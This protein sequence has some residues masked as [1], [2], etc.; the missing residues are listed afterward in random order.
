MLI[1]IALLVFALL[2]TTLQGEAMIQ[3]HPYNNRFSSAPGAHD[4]AFWNSPENVDH[5]RRGA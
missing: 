1:L 5:A 2:R 4:E 3:R